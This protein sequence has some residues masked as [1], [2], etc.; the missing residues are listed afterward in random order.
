V[1]IRLHSYRNCPLDVWRFFHTRQYP[2]CHR[3]GRLGDRVGCTLNFKLTHYQNERLPPHAVFLGLKSSVATILA[4]V[5]TASGCAGSAHPHESRSRWLEG[6]SQADRTKLR[7]LREMVKNYYAAYATSLVALGAS[8]VT[9]IS[10]A[11]EW[12]PKGLTATIAALPGVAVGLTAAFKFE[13]RS[14]W[15][16]AQCKKFDAL[17]LAL[18]FEKLPA[19][20]AS[21]EMRGFIAQH[22]ALWPAFR[23]PSSAS[24]RDNVA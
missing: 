21:K 22:T 9:T 19:S 5:V 17:R 14:D 18:L 15:W 20:Q 2:T 10:V 24:N 3:C 4:I 13:A 16:F 6:V 8:L 1:G 11:I 12:L 23:L 7:A